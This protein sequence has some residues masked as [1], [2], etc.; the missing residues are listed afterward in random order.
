MYR[1]CLFIQKALACGD[2]QENEEDMFAVILQKTSGENSLNTNKLGETA[3]SVNG[4]MTDCDLEGLK[5]DNLPN[6]EP[7]LLVPEKFNPE[8]PFDPRNPPLVKV[9][10]ENGP[11]KYVP[12]NPNLNNKLQMPELNDLGEPIYE[13]PRLNN[14]VVPRGQNPPKHYVPAADPNTPGIPKK[15]DPNLFDPKRP[16]QPLDAVPMTPLRSEAPDVL[17]PKNGPNP[18]KPILMKTPNTPNDYEPPA[19]DLQPPQRGPNNLPK[20][21]DPRLN[22]KVVP[23]G[24]KPPRDYVPAADKNKPYEPIRAPLDPN[25]RLKIFYQHFFEGLRII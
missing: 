10:G 6:L 23:R 8:S 25:L 22:D 7:D 21:E 5:A 1:I 20:Y 2:P 14:K 3:C 4:K 9:P 11:N 16:E 24:Q 19:R 12:A 18:D 13:D 15:V 17:I